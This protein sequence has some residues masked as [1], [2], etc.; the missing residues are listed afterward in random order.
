MTT[1]ARSIAA[2][3]ALIAVLLLMPAVAHAAPAD[4]APRPDEPLDAWL[5]RIALTGVIAGLAYAWTWIRGKKAA[6]KVAK[7]VDEHKLVQ[8]IADQAIDYV[9][10]LD[11]KARKIGD[12]LAESVKDSKALERGLELLEK[13]GFDTKKAKAAAEAELRKVLLSRLGATR[14]K[15]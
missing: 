2:R 12:R 8:L 13:Y 3:C 1:I 14:K 10:E 15:A 6:Q 5:K 4:Y 11:H 7:Y 9:E